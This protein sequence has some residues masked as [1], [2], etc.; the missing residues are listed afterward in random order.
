MDLVLLQMVGPR[1][2]LRWLIEREG[3]RDSNTG[4]LLRLIATSNTSAI[5]GIL[6]AGDSINI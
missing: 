3:R 2:H 1:Q 6:A 4:W 5:A